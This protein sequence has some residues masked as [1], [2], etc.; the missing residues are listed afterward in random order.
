METSAFLGD[1]L[2]SSTFSP[3]RFF[4]ITDVQMC[5][6][7]VNGKYFYIAYIPYVCAVGYAELCFW[8]TLGTQNSEEDQMC[9]ES[10]F[11]WEQKK[12]KN[13]MIPKDV[14]PSSLYPQIFYTIAKKKN[15]RKKKRALK[16]K[17]NIY[18]YIHHMYIISIYKQQL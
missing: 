1:C 13:G 9:G 6:V 18:L 8:I 2:F 5:P 10:T 12:K 16:I 14:K 11:K 3:N 17:K 15:R 4:G 7:T